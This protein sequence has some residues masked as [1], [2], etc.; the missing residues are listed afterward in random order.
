L[1]SVSLPWTEHGAAELAAPDDEGVVEEAALL[2]IGDER[3]GWLIGA[4]T[5]QAQIAW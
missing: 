2:E 5:L 4:A 1:A 3:R